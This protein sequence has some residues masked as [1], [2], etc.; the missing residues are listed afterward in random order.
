MSL[1]KRLCLLTSALLCG[2]SPLFAQ[3]A[4]LQD[5][6]L[7]NLVH[8]PGYQYEP[9]RRA[10]G[11]RR[12]RQGPPRHGAGVGLRR[13]RFGVRR[14]HAP[15]RGSLSHAR[16]DPAGLR[17]HGGAAH[18]RPGYELRRSDLDSRGDGGRGQAHP[19]EELDRRCWSG[20]FINGTQVAM[21]VALEHP[22]MTRGVVLLAGTPR[23]EPV[24]ASRF[25]P[26]TSTLEQKV[27]ADG[28]VQ[29]TA[30]VQDRH[31]RHV[32][33]GK[34]RRHRLLGRLRAGGRFAVA[35]TSRRC[36]CWSATCASST[37]RTCGRISSVSGP[38]CS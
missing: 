28:Q 33:E 8:A 20:H 34:F 6:T 4:A 37:P 26:R 27:Q 32:G 17:G 14:I 1:R 16:C 29:R 7:D 2:A 35:P 36:R 31:A 23:F 19:R 22:E 12:T 10:R 25:W 30:L 3:P 15:Q 11:G 24:T 13:G 5:S 21:R 38:P 9:A 18:A